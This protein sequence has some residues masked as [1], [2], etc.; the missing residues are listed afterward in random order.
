LFTFNIQTTDP[1]NLEVLKRA[2]KPG[3]GRPRG[4]QQ[5]DMMG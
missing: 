1:K 3:A 4:W 2:A 5:L